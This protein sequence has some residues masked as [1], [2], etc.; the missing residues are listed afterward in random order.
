MDETFVPKP[1]ALSE[2][3]QVMVQPSENDLGHGV[4]E[5][6]EASELFEDAV[7]FQAGITVN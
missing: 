1:T 5:N 3:A 4:G 2:A 7:E 6:E